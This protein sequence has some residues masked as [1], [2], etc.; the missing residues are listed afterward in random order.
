MKLPNHSKEEMILLQYFNTKDRDN[1]VALLGARMDGDNYGKMVLYKFPPKQTVYSP[2]IFKQR[3]N[4]DTIIS[5][6]L[7]LWNTQ[8]SQVQFGETLIIPIKSSLLYVEPMYLRANGE[9]SI[10]EMKKVIVSYGDK[11]ILANNIESALQ[12]M[13]DYT[14]NNNISV[15]EGDLNVDSKVL[16]DIKMAKDLYNKALE[17]QK[18][19]KWSEYG[20]YIKQLGDILEK[21][22]K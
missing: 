18:N 3:I 11:M 1:M 17:A 16:G 21:V 7:S 12:Q 20:T 2:V 15:S 13:F 5:K 22:S 9:K 14:D 8:G 4:Q 19:G 10:P 6:E